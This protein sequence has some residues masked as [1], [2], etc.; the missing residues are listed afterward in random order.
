MSNSL[1]PKLYEPEVEAI[2]TRDGY[3]AGLVALGE[4]R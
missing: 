2:A 1:N 4:G 3:G